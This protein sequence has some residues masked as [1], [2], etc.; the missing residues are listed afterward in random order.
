MNTF[1]V[2]TLRRLLD[3]TLDGMALYEAIRDRADGIVDFKLVGCNQK[4][5][6]LMGLTP[7]QA[8]QYTLRQLQSTTRKDEVFEQWRRVAQT[9][10]AHQ[11]EQYFPELGKWYTVSLT[12]FDDQVLA[13][14]NDITTLKQ[15]EL[16]QE[17]QATFLN[18]LVQTSAS[19][20]IV[21]EAI[22]AHHASGVILD[23]KTVFFNSAYEEVIG[24][25]GE[26]IRSQTFKERFAGEQFTP[27]F[28]FYSE[29]TES[30]VPFRREVYYPHIQKW[31]DVSGTR[32]NDGFLVMLYDITDRKRAEEERRQ[33]SE[34]LSSI[35][36][37]IDN[38]IVALQAV[39]APGLDGQPGAIV[40]FTYAL[41]NQR[42]SALV[43]VSDDEMIG[44]RLLTIFPGARKT[45]L[46]DLYLKT[47]ESG[48]PQYQEIHYNE[49][50]LE[51]WVAV[52][53]SKLEDGV[54]VSFTNITSFKKYQR[55]IED[56]AAQ[57]ATSV[58]ELQRS[59]SSLQQFAYVASHDLQEPLRKI[60]AFG[61]VL[62]RKFATSLGTD[63]AG[64]VGRMQLAA[65]RMSE[66]ITDLL[67]YSRITTEHTSFQP[68]ALSQVIAHALE[69]LE[70]QVQQAGAQIEV[71]ALPTVLGDLT[72]LR[73]LFHNL[74]SNAIKFR[75][76][77]VTPRVQVGCRL[78]TE[79]EVPAAI[80]PVTPAP[81]FYEISVSDNGIGF[82]EKY[83]DQIF[84]MFHRLHGKM[85][86]RGTGIGLAICQKVA[87]THN[88]AIT[89][90]SAP[91]QG[92]TFYVYLP[93]Q[94]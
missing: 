62:Q 10:E 74:L 29:L 78:L 42:V 35:L 44:K 23:F 32:L 24:E 1:S 8:R 88:G 30:G 41:V 51:D 22:R 19:G 2:D 20:I 71:D 7:E 34:L 6:D 67:A 47:I 83:L 60:Q 85:E 93:T 58:E 81:A 94:L 27:L 70:L 57:L 14:C 86:Y 76:P 5:A 38:A 3:A 55:T 84:E 48:E 11:F 15:T 43:G 13:T 66:L 25:A 75:K 21:Y 9:G 68:V 90:H 50:G 52:R 16:A 36:A 33:Q 59:N 17:Q 92:A 69:N 77:E 49:D 39:R 89:A 54:V 80:R 28:Q 40:D 64:L 61:D 56:T 91:D 18:K 65:E 46:F 72:Q 73:Q 82:D 87:Q 12:R 45:G 53:S 63:G 79:M 26:R 4:A 31:L 37:N